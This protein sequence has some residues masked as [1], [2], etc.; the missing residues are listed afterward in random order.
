[1]NQTKGKLKQYAGKALSQQC[2]AI[3]SLDQAS[4]KLAKMTLRTKKAQYSCLLKMDI[5]LWCTSGLKSSQKGILNIFPVI[6]L[7]FLYQ[8]LN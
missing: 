7:P 1:M 6:K 8:F 4:A 3:K 2:R 5:S